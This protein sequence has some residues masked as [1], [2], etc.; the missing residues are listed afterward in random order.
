MEAQGHHEQAAGGGAAASAVQ[1]ARGTERGGPRGPG[2]HPPRRQVRLRAA[3]GEAAGHL[4]A[5]AV[6]V[7]PQQ[8]E[9]LQAG[10]HGGRVLHHPLR[11]V[12]RLHHGRQDGELHHRRHAVLRGLLRGAGPDAGGR[13]AAGDG[14]DAGGVRVREAEE[15]GLRQHPQGLRGEV[16]EDEDPVPQE[17]PHPV[18]AGQHR[19]PEPR[20]RAH[21]PGLRAEPDRVQAGPGDGR[22]LPPR[23]RELQGGPGGEEL[24]ERQ[25][26][27]AAA[28][29]GA[30]QRGVTR[31][32]ATSCGCRR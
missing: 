2:G 32:R 8:R 16:P 27:A 24:P 5:H 1:E 26:E 21:R 23:V 18:P 19:H 25:D 4:P 22:H 29:G 30:E 31:G 20:V 17:H 3:P 13:A 15:G 6:R 11:V 12:H 7:L 28:A 14:D 9:H 10:G